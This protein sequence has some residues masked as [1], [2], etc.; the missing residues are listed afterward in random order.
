MINWLGHYHQEVVGLSYIYNKV[1]FIAEW[2][3]NGEKT[4]FFCFKQPDLAAFLP[5][6]KRTMLYISLFILERGFERA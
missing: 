4:P 5:E 1:L 6:L 3:G 2:G